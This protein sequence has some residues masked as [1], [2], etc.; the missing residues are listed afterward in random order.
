MATT[1]DASA[2]GRRDA[3]ITALL[4]SLVA[5]VSLLA[6]SEAELAK[7]EL[8][9]KASKAGMGL[10][11]IAGAAAFAFYALGALIAAA[12]LAL[13]IVLPAWA[14]ALIAGGVLVAVA[15]TL[16]QIGRR[17]LREGMPFVPARTLATAEEDISWIR[18][19]I[20]A[21]RPSE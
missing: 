6:R 11:L 4:G 13:A 7:I 21:L 1:T 18:S 9:E 19:K 10:G 5:D 17:R 8:K 20:E 14:A 12:V 2:N 15:A 16:A 3:S